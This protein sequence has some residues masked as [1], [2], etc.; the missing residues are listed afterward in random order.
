MKCNRNLTGLAAVGLLALFT[1]TASAKDWFYTKIPL[2]ATL[3]NMIAGANAV[4]SNSTAQTAFVVPQGC[5]WSIVIPNTATNANSTAASATVYSFD[6][7][8]DNTNWTS[9]HPLTLAVTEN[10]TSQNG[11]G[12]NFMSRLAGSQQGWQYGRMTAVTAGPTNQIYTPYFLIGTY[13]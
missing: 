5:D 2:T 3:S 7:S 12:T 1:L 10:G 11:A 9:G 8:S 13:Q 4:T 6:F